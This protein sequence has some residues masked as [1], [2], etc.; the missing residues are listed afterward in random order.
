MRAGGLVEPFRADLRKL[1]RSHLG[2][3]AVIFFSQGLHSGRGGASKFYSTAEPDYGADGSS[4]EYL[5]H[6]GMPMMY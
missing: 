2:R 4:F 1:V 5:S 3:G 6:N